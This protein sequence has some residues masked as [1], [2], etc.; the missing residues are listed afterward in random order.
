MISKVY[1]DDYDYV[2]VLRYYYQLKHSRGFIPQTVVFTYVENLPKKSKSLILLSHNQGYK[3][4]RY[5]YSRYVKS[6]IEITN[7][8]PK[9]CL[10]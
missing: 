3:Y 4:S 1:L 9:E 2:L 6:L 5:K 8:I 7:I 10:D